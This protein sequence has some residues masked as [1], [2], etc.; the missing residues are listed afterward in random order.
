MKATKNDETTPLLVAQLAADDPST[1]KH[2]AITPLPK[3]QLGIITCMRLVEPIAYTQIFPY[4]NEFLNDLHVTDDPRRIGFYS[5][6][7]ESVYAVFQLVSIYH[8]AKMSDRIGRRPVILSGLIGVAISTFLFGLSGSLPMML[9]CRALSGLSSGNAAVM[10]SV[11]SEITDSSNFGLAAPLFGLSWSIGSILGPLLGGTFST[12]AEK[13]PWLDFSFLRKHPYSLPGSISSVATFT[14]VIVGYFILRETLPSKVRANRKLSA[15]PVPET[16]PHMHAEP[17][18]I[19]ELLSNPTIFAI[20]MSSFWLSFLWLGSEVVFVLYSYTP[21][22]H[23]GLG[24]PAKQIGYALSGSGVLSVAMQLF[25]MPYIL[26]TFDKAKMYN[27]CFCMYPLLFPIMSVLN[28]IA[29]AGYDEATETLSAQ[30]TA[31]VWAGIALL[32][33]MSRF[34]MIAFALSFV[35]IKEHCPNESSVAMSYGIAAFMQ[36]MSRAV[37]PTIMS[38]IYAVSQEYNILY[39]FG[40]VPAMSFIALLGVIQS[41]SV[42]RATR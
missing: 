16:Q 41:T 34:A 22:P 24:F 15:T 32:L 37:S 12:P 10:Q 33:L 21:V 7:V 39:G 13:Y 31:A 1:T 29:R 4:I 28:I 19:R 11:V 40:W 17:L 35:L 8:F 27:L 9:V 14:A 38:S 36:C 5:G 20:S 30:T 18:G 25:L 42:V 3:L 2:K 23:G 6:L 26:R